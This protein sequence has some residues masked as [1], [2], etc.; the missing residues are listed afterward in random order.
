VLLG[1]VT[2]TDPAG[3]TLTYSGPITS[4]GGATVSVGA[5]GSY[6]YTPTQVQ[7]QAATA[8]SADTFLVTVSNGVTSAS[9]TVTVPGSWLAGTP[10]YGGAAVSSSDRATGVLNGSVAFTDPAG[11]T[12][13][14]SGST[15]STDVPTM[16]NRIP[17]CLRQWAN[18]RKVLITSSHHEQRFATIGMLCQATNGCI[19]PT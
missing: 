16:I 18:T 5:D 1:S 15:T 8:S 6:T 7:R 9:K 4:V 19:N 11:R 10:T 3:L 13:T 14:Y 2:F 12:L 17:H